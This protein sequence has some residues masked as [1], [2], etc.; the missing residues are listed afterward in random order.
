MC[1]MKKVWAQL[2]RVL[3][4]SSSRVNRALITQQLEALY[5]LPINCEAACRWEDAQRLFLRCNGHRPYYAGIMD[6][7]TD[8]RLAVASFEENMLALQQ[9][10]LVCTTVGDKAPPC[11][12]GGQTSRGLCRRS[13]IVCVNVGSC[14]DLDLNMHEDCDETLLTLLHG[15]VVPYLHFRIVYGASVS[16]PLVPRAPGPAICGA[17]HD[18]SLQNELHMDSCVALLHPRGLCSSNCNNKAY[19]TAATLVRGAVSLATSD[20]LLHQRQDGCFTLH[21][22]AMKLGSPR[23]FALQLWWNKEVGPVIQRGVEQSVKTDEVLSGA[24]IEVARKRVEELVERGGDDLPQPLR[25]MTRDDVAAFAADATL[26]WTLSAF[27]CNYKRLGPAQPA[28]RLQFSEEARLSMALE[29]MQTVKA[30]LVKQPTGIPISELSATVCWPAAS[31]WIG[32]KSLTE[33][34]TQFPAHFNV[35]NVEG[36]LVV[37][38]GH[39]TGPSDNVTA[40]EVSEWLAAGHSEGLQ[41]PCVAASP[42]DLTFHRE[43]DLVVRAVAFLRKRHFGNVPVTYGELCGALL[44]KNNGKNDGDSDT[45]LNVLLRYD[46]LAADTA[47]GD[48][49]INIQCGLRDG[50]AIRLSVREDRA[51]RALEAFRT[52]SRSAF[53]LYTEAIEPFLTCCRGAMR[54]N[55]SCVVPLT[56]LERWLQVERLSLQSKELLDILRS[57]EGPY[58]IDEELC[59][60]VLTNHT[61]K[62]EVLTPAFSLPATPPPPPPPAVSSR[63]TFEAQISRVLKTQRPDRLLHFVQTILHA[64]FDLI[65]PHVSAPSGVPVRMLMRRIRWGSFVVTLGSLTS[66]VE[67]FDGLF[68]EVLSNASSHG[69]EKRDDVDLIVSAYKGPVSPWLLYARLIVRLFPAD[70]DIPLGLIAEA[71]S[72][73]SRFAPMFGDLPSLLRR[74]G[75]QCRNGQLLAKVEMV[76]P[77]CD[78]DDA[79]LWELLAKIRR[80]AHLHHLERSSGETGQYVLLSETELYAY[81][82]NDVKGERWN[83]TVKEEGARCLATMAVHRLPHFFEWH[84]DNTDT[85]TRYVRV[86]LPFSTPP[87]GVVCFVEEYVCPLLRQHKQTT[88]A[89]LDEQ[90]GWSHGA[91]DAHP[92]GSQAAGGTPSA[93]SLCGLLRRYVESMHSPKIILEPQETTLSPLHHHVHVMPNSAVYTSPEDMLLLLN[94]LR[95]SN[96]GITRVLPTHKPVSLFEL[97]S[98]QLDLHQPFREGLTTLERG[99]RWN[100]MLACESDSMDDCLQELDNCTGDILVWCEG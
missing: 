78:Q 36:K 71:L 58:R 45:L 18:L 40:E 85:T 17:S 6:Q 5:A 50:D 23:L 38:H 83:S 91:F 1:S 84:V 52:T 92:A 51:L 69:E 80:E 55:G 60:V 44:P 7:S 66:F 26:C 42:S 33:A 90:L 39:L 67:A 72:W 30:S 68:F 31:A 75:R 37:M 99:S 46:V 64:V 4:P 27:D 87:T 25:N 2:E 21:P 9:R 19:R 70:V 61:A 8:N 35:V 96:E 97:I 81:L 3:Q 41:K 56:L 34:L 15:V 53:Q 13:S 79:C 14:A 29:L 11:V 20:T 89:E 93:T 100:V 82:P 65:L 62:G 12:V 47:K 59:N 94:G 77:V 16:P 10:G 28:C 63:L 24:W 48:S 57:A 88:I 49:S 98:Q 22:D 73:S 74:V 76:R 95:I 43:T 54:E 86:V 32:E